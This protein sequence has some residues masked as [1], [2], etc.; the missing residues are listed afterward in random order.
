MRLAP[1]RHGGW[2]LAQKLDRQ[3]DKFVGQHRAA[4]QAGIAVV[5]IAYRYLRAGPDVVINLLL[6]QPH[7]SGISVTLQI[8]PDP[9]VPVAKAPRKQL[10]PGIEQ[11]PR[12]L[13][14]GA[15]DNHQ[16]R[17]LV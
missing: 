5:E 14:R 11:Q 7:R 6:E 8:S 16:V 15:R 12:R 9:V 1:A 2:N 13:D 4:R 3:A 10:A 17:A